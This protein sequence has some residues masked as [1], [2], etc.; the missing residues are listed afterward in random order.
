MYPALPDDPGHAIWKRDFT[1]ACSL[2]SVVLHTASKE[3]VA[4]MVDGF[5]LFKLGASWGGYESLIVP[6]NLAAT[7]TARPWTESGFVLRFHI[8]LE[9]TDDIISDLEDG[10]KRLNHGMNE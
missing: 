9:D 8:G 3:A 5:R 7:R 4:R 10:F 2:F 6:V 1:G